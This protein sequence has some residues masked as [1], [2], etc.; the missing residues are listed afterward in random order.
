MPQTN[1]TNTRASKNNWNNNAG[2]GE[3]VEEALAAKV[4]AIAETI[5]GTIQSADT[6]LK[7]K[8]KKVLF[9]SL[10]LQKENN[11][12]R[13]T[14]RLLMLYQYYA[15]TKDSDTSMKSFVQI[16][17]RSKQPSCR[18]IIQT[19]RNGQL[20]IKCML[21]SSISPKRW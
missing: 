11:E 17:N 13:N 15:Q 9:S 12:L 2:R 1:N 6:H 10:Q 21:M 20:H 4:A 14:R 8:R 7:E 16:R 18:H 5:V 19:Q 3:R